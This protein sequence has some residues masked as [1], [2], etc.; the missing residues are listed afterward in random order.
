MRHRGV[1]YLISGYEAR[2]RAARSIAS[3]ERWGLDY[4]IHSVEGRQIGS[5]EAD[6]LQLTPFRE[7][8]WLD[9][10]ALVVDD[11][12]FGFEMAA[13]HGCA[14]SM[15]P[16]CWARRQWT[17]DPAAPVRVHRE[18]PEYD[19]GAVFFTGGGSVHALFAAWRGL[20]GRCGSCPHTAFSQAVYDIGSNPYVLPENWNFRARPIVCG[21]IKIWNSRVAPPLNIEQWNARHPGLGLI[22]DGMIEPVDWTTDAFHRTYP[23]IGPRASIPL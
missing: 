8:L 11:I 6:L 21:P 23:R 13:R 2:Q 18:I 12:H 4:C 7:T 19:L 17:R 5:P 10:D 3:L 16:A 1:L 9:P 15:S 20:A 14:V 22:A